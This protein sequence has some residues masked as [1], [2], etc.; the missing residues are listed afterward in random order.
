M[1]LRD[2]TSATSNS[3]A[4]RVWAYNAREPSPRLASSKAQPDTHFDLCTHSHCGA[5]SSGL[6]ETIA[7]FRRVH[8]LKKPSSGAPL[9]REY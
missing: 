6:R 1:M 7:N 2:R 8:P 4:L 9:L 5:L 3:L